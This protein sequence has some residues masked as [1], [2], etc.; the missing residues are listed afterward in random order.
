L[1]HALAASAASKSDSSYLLA[2]TQV[3]E[4]FCRVFDKAT[5][6]ALGKALAQEVTETGD[7]ASLA[8]LARA[9]IPLLEPPGHDASPL[10]ASVAAAVF[11]KAASDDN[12]AKLGE[13]LFAL[14]ATHETA[15]AEAVLTI[16]LDEWTAQWGGIMLPKKRPDLYRRAAQARLLATVAPIL[17]DV[18]AAYATKGLLLVLPGTPD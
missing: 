7:P 9:V 11:G 14:N 4:T 1:V 10:V 5:V 15:A 6:A 17:D 18:S 16:L 13:A 2:L 12:K 8:A 3:A